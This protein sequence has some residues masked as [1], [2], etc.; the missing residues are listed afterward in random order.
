MDCSP[1]DSS[2]HGIL[3]ARILEWKKKKKKNTRMGCCFLLHGIFPNQESNRA[4][5]LCGCILFHLSHQESPLGRE[6]PCVFWSWYWFC[7]FF[8]ISG[9]RGTWSWGKCLHCSISFAYFNHRT[10][11]KMTEKINPVGIDQFWWIAN[12]AFKYIVLETRS[13]SFQRQSQLGLP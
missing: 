2:I 3:W 11:G 8:H 13:D 6:R 7:Q 9:S 4:L 10:K 5:L 12:C 1:P